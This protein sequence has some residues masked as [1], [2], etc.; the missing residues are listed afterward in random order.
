MLQL[1]PPPLPHRQQ[2]MVGRMQALV[3]VAQSLAWSRWVWWRQRRRQQCQ[4][5]EQAHTPRRSAWQA[6]AVGR[7]ALRMV[8]KASC[9]HMWHGYVRDVQLLLLVCAVAVASAVVW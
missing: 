4:E 3:V 7:A 5:E 8:Q 1:H 2:L 9:L 6:A